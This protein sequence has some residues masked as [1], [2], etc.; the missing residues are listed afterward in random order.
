M[1]I[2]D[3]AS[4]TSVRSAAPGRRLFWLGWGLLFLGLGIYVIQ[5]FALKQYVV[6][7][8]APSLAT[9]GVIGMLIATV[10][11]W[12]VWRLLGLAVC[13]VVVSFEWLLLLTTGAPAYKGPKAGDLV[14]AF[15]A[16]RADGSAFSERDLAGQPTVLLLFRGHW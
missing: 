14:S 8:Y 4:D 5:F 7:W 3:I 10:Q 12:S 9:V 1:A 2:E 13:L 16:I 6:P 11:R 15:S